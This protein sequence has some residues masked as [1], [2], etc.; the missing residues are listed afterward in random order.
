MAVFKILGSE[1]QAEKRFDS[2]PHFEI[3]MISGTLNVGDRFVLYDTHHPCNYDIV[4][5]T[6]AD[7]GIRIE[8]RQV[9]MWSDAW[10]GAIVDTD[11]PKAAQQY[12]T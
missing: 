3:E 4:S 12:R 5:V 10:K 6:P 8:V 2:H 9:I 11:N 1:P 7:A